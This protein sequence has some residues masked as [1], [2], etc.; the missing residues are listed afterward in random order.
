MLLGIVV[1]YMVI[2]WT[3]I[4]KKHKGKW[5]ALKSDEKTVIASGKTAKQVLATAKKKGYDHPILT[6]MPSSLVS[7]VG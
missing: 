7:L 2:N 3:T 6:K 4:Y 5:V 1:L